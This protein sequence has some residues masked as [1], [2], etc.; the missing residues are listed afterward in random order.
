MKKTVLSVLLLAV[1]GTAAYTGSNG[2]RNKE[3]A[4]QAALVS[5][6]TVTSYVSATGSVI[7]REELT[8]NSPVSGQLLDVR[9]NEGDEVSAGQLLASFESREQ[10]VVIKKAASS[11]NSVMQRSAFAVSDSERQMRV[12]QVGGESRKMVEDA[13]LRVV[14]LREEQTIAEQNLRQAQYD[15]DKL[16]LTA[17]KRSV[18][19]ARLARPGAWVRVGTSCL[20]LPRPTREILR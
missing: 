11:V 9:V 3:L 5:R 16:K 4:L 12:F 6:G 7:N 13:Q 14:T 15:L 8:M 19:T 2:L 1:L 17:P 10:A 18:V 20:S